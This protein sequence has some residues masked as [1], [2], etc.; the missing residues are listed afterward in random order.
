MKPYRGVFLTSALFGGD[1]SASRPGRFIREERAP[2]THWVGG[3]VGPRAGLD[4]SPARSQ[5]LYR[6]RYPGSSLTTI[7]LMNY[8]Y[9]P[10]NSVIR[11]CVYKT[12]AFLPYHQLSVVQ[13]T[14]FPSILHLPSS[15]FFLFQNSSWI[16]Y[17]FCS[18]YIHIVFV[19]QKITAD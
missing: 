12:S 11:N 3:W 8:L 7:L 5:S 18:S 10:E 14:A 2:G 16:S 6:L 9:N 17:T 13:S 19:H 15:I 1:W 4:D